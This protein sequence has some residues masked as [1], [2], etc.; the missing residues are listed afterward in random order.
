MHTQKTILTGAI[1]ALR[2]L[3]KHLSIRGHFKLSQ[4]FRGWWEHHPQRTPRLVSSPT[5]GNLKYTRPFNL[6]KNVF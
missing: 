2:K 3:Y 5:G 6:R 1:C 4:A